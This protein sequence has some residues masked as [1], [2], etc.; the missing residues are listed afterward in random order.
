MI[1]MKK[2]SV[3]ILVMIM[4]TTLAACNSENPATDASISPTQSQASDSSQASSPSQASTP[5]ETPAQSQNQGALET[6]SD[7]APRDFTF[8]IYNESDYDIY[9]IHM[10]PLTGTA[11]DDVDI[12]DYI[13]ASGDDVLITGSVSGHL[14]SITEWT[15]YI[16]D[17]DDDTSSSFDV[18][19]PF[20]LSYVDVIWDYDSAGYRCQ[21]NY[22]GTY[23]NDNSYDY[24]VEYSFT[25]YN[26]SDYTIYSI[27]MGPLGSSS[28]DDVDILQSTLA[29]GMSADISG[30]IPAHMGPDSD[31]TL[32]VTDV[33]GDTSVSYETFKPSALIYVDIVWDSSAG[34]YRCEFVY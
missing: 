30:V 19:N 6:R 22:G 16:T 24:N 11:E 29:P 8:R 3:L 17:V 21:F 15:L 18:F 10:G 34:G 14:T 33:D 23:S 27:H 28:E 12:L 5:A 1:V 26:E 2:I 9:A 20:S 32:Y 25:I 7:S 31:W 13:L 4:I